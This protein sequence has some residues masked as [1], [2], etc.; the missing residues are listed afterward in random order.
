MRGSKS[1]GPPF[2]AVKPTSLVV[3]PQLHC[4]FFF[5]FKA[6]F[7][8]NLDPREYILM[9]H[10]RRYSNMRTDSKNIS[11]DE[12][13]ITG[14]IT[15]V[16]WAE[17]WTRHIFHELQFSLQKNNYTNSRYL[18][19]IFSKINQISLIFQARK[20]TEALKWKLSPM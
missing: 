13:Y 3:R 9:L 17:G 12:H 15:C 19:E 14:K 8:R 4:I 7:T 5:F 10:D 18:E 6:N 16:L 1:A 2:K 20:K 11:A